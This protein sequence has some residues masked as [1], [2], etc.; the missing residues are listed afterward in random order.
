MRD[1][2]ASIEKLQLEIRPLNLQGSFVF[3]D[4]VKDVS[5]LLL[6]FTVTSTDPILL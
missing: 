3:R 6:L 2:V 5:V 4:V 1:Y